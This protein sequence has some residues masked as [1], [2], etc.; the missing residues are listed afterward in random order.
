MEKTIINNTINEFYGI[1]PHLFKMSNQKFWL[2]YDNEADVLYINYK[3]P[4][5]ANDSEMLDNGVLI[6]YKDE[7]IVGITILDASKRVQ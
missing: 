5:R 4:Q 1:L 6:R 7:E 2:D 3:K